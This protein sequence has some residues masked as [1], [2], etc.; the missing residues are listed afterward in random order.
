MQPLTPY[1]DEE[2]AVEISYEPVDGLPANGASVD[3]GAPIGGY[4]QSGN[5]REVGKWGSEE[6]LVTKALLGINAAS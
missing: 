6:F 4:Q 5:G 1:T 3:P 2:H